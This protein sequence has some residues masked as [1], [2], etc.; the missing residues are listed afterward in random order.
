MC[1]DHDGEPINIIFRDGDP[2]SLLSNLAATPFVLDDQH[3]ASVEAF[4]QAIKYPEDGPK[5]ARRHRIATLTGHAARRAGTNPNRKISR[6]WAEGE[7][8]WVYWAGR[9]ILY[10]SESH[11][12]LIERA[13]RAKFTQSTTALA[14]LRG[15][16]NRALRHAT[17]AP[18]RRVTSLKAMELCR[19][20]TDIRTEARS[21][22]AVGRRRRDHRSP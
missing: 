11:A 14:V 6:A 3:F 17:G 5:A 20:L 1:T 16:G 13:I 19:I 15:T 7:E 2:L 22:N 21:R 12:M 8:A 9:H 4:I 10:Q 18:E